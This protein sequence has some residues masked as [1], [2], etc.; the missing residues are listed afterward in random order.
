MTLWFVDQAVLALGVE[1]PLDPLAH[2]IT[3]VTS[4]LAVRDTRNSVFGDLPLAENPGGDGAEAEEAGDIL[5]KA[6]VRKNF[7]SVPYFN[8]EIHVGPSGKTK[9]TIQLPDNLTLFKIR[10]KAVSGSDRFGFGTS[11][12]PSDTG[13]VLLNLTVADAASSGFVTVYACGSPRQT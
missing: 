4:Y 2:F 7:K 9:V 8:P 3:P 12:I 10:A 11:Q 5:D 13:T 1:Q 6:T